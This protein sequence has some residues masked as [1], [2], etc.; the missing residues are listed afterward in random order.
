MKMIASAILIFAFSE[1]N[2][3][4]IKGKD[5][6]IPLLNTVPTIP[7]HALTSNDPYVLQKAAVNKYL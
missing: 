4:K 3:L 7:I 2:S 5:T 1:I 6:Q